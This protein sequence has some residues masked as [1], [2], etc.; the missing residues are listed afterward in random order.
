MSQLNQEVIYLSGNE[1]KPITS[2]YGP[3]DYFYNTII[4]RLENLLKSKGDFFATGFAGCS[5][6]T[7]NIIAE[8]DALRCEVIH[9]MFSNSTNT[10]SE[11]EKTLILTPVQKNYYNRM[12]D[13]QN[14][15]FVEKYTVILPRKSSF[16]DVKVAL[17][18]AYRH[19]GE[20]LTKST[21]LVRGIIKL[22][23]N[24]EED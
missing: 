11:G 8:G 12:I 7:H 18:L 1:T 6:I 20:V 15:R 9:P 13:V 3:G 16:K 19:T 14:I 24:L 21:D 22:A 5:F 17:E 23:K 4:E 2:H 10:P